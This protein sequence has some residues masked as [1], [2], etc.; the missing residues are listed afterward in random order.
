MNHAYPVFTKEAE[1]QDCY[2]CVRHCPVKAIRVRDGHAAVI[3][4]MCVA[5]GKCVEVCPVKAKQIRNDSGRARFLLAEKI[6]V[7]LS[8]APSWV[9]EF[10][11]VTLPQ[12]VLAAKMLG[13]AGVS[14]TALGAQIVSSYAAEKLQNLPGGVYLS[15]ACPTAVDFIRRYLPE[16][17]CH[18]TPV[19][20]PLLTHCRML[21]D[22]FGENIRIIFAGPCIGKKNE[23]DRN[24]D[25]LNLALTF[26]ELRTMFQERGIVPEKLTPNKDDA[27]V[28]YVAEEGALYPV[29]GGMNDTIRFQCSRRDVHYVVASGIKEIRRTLEK[30]NFS[31]EK[32][33]IFVELLACH[34]GCVHGPAAGRGMPGLSERMQVEDNTSFPDSPVKRQTSGNIEMTFPP[35]IPPEEAPESELHDILG[36]L[37][38]IGKT[39]PE[40]ELNCDGCGYDSCRNFARALL[41]G[42]AEP[43]M[44]VSYLKK[45]AQKKANALLRSISSGVVITD[46]NLQIIECNRNFAKLFGEDTLDAFDAS[47]G[48]AGADLRR[49]L[50]FYQ[51]F[52]AALRSGSDIRRD[53]IR[54]GKRMFNVNVFIIEPGETVGAV[55]FDVTNTELRR[56]LIAARARQVIDKNLATVQEIACQLGEH[57]ADTELL[58]RSIADDYADEKDL[59]PED[60]T[61]SNANGKTL[62]NITGE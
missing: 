24:K 54:V 59:L 5:C 18:F 19:G 6:P 10:R 25:L 33:V 43:S 32:H 21:R 12:M 56:E 55:I 60:E 57:M 27:A 50:P 45:Q 8:L 53:S 16:Q 2:K 52:E 48:L 23:S 29:E 11:N 34:G 26:Q 41:T 61:V 13:F 17:T 4:E 51:L 3:P 7:Y 15:T 62:E 44:C 37:R 47:P 20:S 14:E 1:C 36:A 22:T 38:S 30:F 49:I 42:H 35:D 9:S 28:P 58:L 31:D 46:R 39:T 40:D